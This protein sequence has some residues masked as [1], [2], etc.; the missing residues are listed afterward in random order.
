[1]KREKK[2]F[3]CVHS[4]S[5]CVYMEKQNEG[6]AGLI[7]KLKINWIQGSKNADIMNI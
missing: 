4:H 1:M 5:T 3:T 7:T 6:V 2:T